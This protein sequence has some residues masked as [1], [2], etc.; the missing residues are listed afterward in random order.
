MTADKQ[1]G[2][3]DP[4]PGFTLIEVMIPLTLFTIGLLGISGMLLIGET[5]IATGNRSLSAV[6][7]SRAQMEQLKGRSNIEAGGGECT[8]LFPADI[9]CQWE[10]RG[11][12][13]SAGLYDIEVKASWNEG[14]RKRELVLNTIRFIK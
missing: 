6:Q 9:G 8:V 13:P 14:E 4:S 12:T 7:I 10:V 2:G 5:G 1:R 11:D 3:G